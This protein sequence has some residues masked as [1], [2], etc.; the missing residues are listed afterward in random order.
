VLGVDTSRPVRP[1]DAAATDSPVAI[2]TPD[3]NS[4]V[5][6]GSVVRGRA[7][8]PDGRVYWAVYRNDGL[9]LAGHGR[10][11]AGP[12]CTS[13]PFTFRLPTLAR[14]SPYVLVVGSEA[15]LGDG[16]TTVDTKEFS[17]R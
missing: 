2:E 17:I 16:G 8:T 7:S 15:D 10:S 11:E 9:V 12:C 3:D 5:H 13:T 4:F 14:G 6:S 1:A